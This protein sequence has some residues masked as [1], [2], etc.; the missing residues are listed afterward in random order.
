MDGHLENRIGISAISSY[1]PPWVLPNDWF[2]G[3]VPRKFVHHTG[4][5]S[6][7]IAQEDEPTL[8][9]RAVKSL[10]REVG[11]DLA[12][13]AALVF[14]SPS[15]IPPAIA[16]K[17]GGEERARAESLRQAGQ[18]LVR[19]L[20]IP[21][22]RVAAINWFCSGY[23][24]ALSLVANR[25]FPRLNLQPH[26]FVLVVT[27][28]RISRITDYGC[29]QTCALFGDL[30][31][32]TMISRLDSKRHPV[33]FELLYA[34]AQKLPADG[35]YFDFHLRQNVA[36]PTTEG[37]RIQEPER[38]VFSLDG[39]SIADAA[40][41][42]MANAVADALNATGLTPADIRFVVP[43]QAGTGII[44][45]AAMKIEQLGIHGEVINGLTQRVGNVS[46]SSIPYSFRQLWPRLTGTIACPTAAV[47]SPGV[48]EV[49]QGCVLLRATPHHDRLAL[50]VA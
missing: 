22:C 19:R 37:G 45:L 8:G 38:L 23:S 48:R 13:C 29:P 3:I 16:R 26:Q 12:D 6:R 25:I 24:R 10:Q 49:S 36:L 30:A 17:F 41:R 1:E 34:D 47:G 14:A 21:Q 43:H 2:A 33:H 44:R 18:Q 32:A 31:T 20:G 50:A 27:A 39:M 11:C 46:S 40:P 28:T 15:F 35:V 4:I 7:P 9:Y 5:E 42:A